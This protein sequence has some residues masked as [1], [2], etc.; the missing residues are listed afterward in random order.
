MGHFEDQTFNPV[1]PRVPGTGN[2]KS[3]NGLVGVMV[4]GATSASIV[5]FLNPYTLPLGDAAS[6]KCL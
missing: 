2:P 6:C 3:P 5:Q 4:G 1:E